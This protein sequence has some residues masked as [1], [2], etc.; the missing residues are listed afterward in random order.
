MENRPRMNMMEAH[1]YEEEARRALEK[2]APDHPALKKF[3]PS[4]WA[5]SDAYD[6]A[7]RE[8]RELRKS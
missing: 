4:T 2:I 5:A 1:E 8:L 3:Y 7:L 6:E